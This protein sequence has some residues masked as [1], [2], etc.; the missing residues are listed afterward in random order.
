MTVRI[1]RYELFQPQLQEAFNAAVI[2]ADDPTNYVD[3][4]LFYRVYNDPSDITTFG[5]ANEISCQVPACAYST[6]TGCIKV[7]ETRN[8]IVVPEPGTWDSTDEEYDIADWVESTE[9]NLV[10]INYYAGLRPSP[11]IFNGPQ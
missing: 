10:W 11:G 4:V 3:E 5:W 1:P 8:G 2:D 7:R 6:Q 9:P